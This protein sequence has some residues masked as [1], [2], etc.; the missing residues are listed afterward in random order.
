MQ[1]E[2]LAEHRPEG[3]IYFTDGDGPF[4]PEAPKV[5]VLWVLTKPA[6]FACPWGERARL[7][8]KGR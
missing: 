3:V 7:E 2:F 6:T 5:P 1:A 4:H 8:R